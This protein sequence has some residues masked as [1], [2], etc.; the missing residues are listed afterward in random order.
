MNN[1]FNDM[2]SLLMESA[3]YKNFIELY[4][5]EKTKNRFF[6]KMEE[7]TIIVSKGNEKELEAI[8]DIVIDYLSDIEKINFILGIKISF[9][10]FEELKRGVFY[11]GQ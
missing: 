11:D 9:L 5:D 3:E 8:K 1:I 7:L 6:E 2:V 4:Q 10:F